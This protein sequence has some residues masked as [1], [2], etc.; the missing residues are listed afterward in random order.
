ML[1]L[2][3]S[4]KALFK[5]SH[6]FSREPLAILY[7]SYIVPQGSPLLVLNHLLITTIINKHQ[8]RFTGPLPLAN[9]LAPGWRDIEEA[10]GSLH[11]RGAALAPPKKEVPGG[12][13]VGAADHGLAH[14]GFWDD[15]RFTGILH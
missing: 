6:H 5:N 9:S 1:Y 14:L 4:F 7:T 12:A 10:G 13:Q 3:H 15:I 11:E 8:L 2:P